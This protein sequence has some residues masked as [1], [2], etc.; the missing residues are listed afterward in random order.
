MAEKAD[1]LS[2]DA[3]D[4]LLND[5]STSSE[6]TSRQDPSDSM[7][8]M[9][10]NVNKSLGTMADSLLAMNQWLYHL[11]SEPRKTTDGELHCKKSKK[12][13]TDVINASDNNDNNSDKEFEAFCGATAEDAPKD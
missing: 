11:H 4:A 7:F 10:A 8:T 13:S 1:Q 9:I 5:E 2:L 3:E 12:S 6:T